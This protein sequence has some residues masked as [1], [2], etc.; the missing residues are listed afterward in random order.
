MSSSQQQ[1]QSSQ[2]NLQGQSQQG[3]GQQG[4]KHPTVKQ[5]EQ[6]RHKNVG[7]DLNANQHQKSRQHDN[8]KYQQ[9]QEKYQSNFGSSNKNV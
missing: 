1:G 7:E 2:S 4:S 3:L 5:H 8:Q 6:R 9:N